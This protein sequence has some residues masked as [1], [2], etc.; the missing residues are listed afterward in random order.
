MPVAAPRPSGPPLNALRAF[1]AAARLGGFTAA[2]GE[3]CVTPGAI[4]QHVKTLEAW[5]G[6]QLFERHGKGVRLTDLGTAVVAEFSAAF[7]HLGSAVQSLRATAL[8][9]HVR[10]AALP[11]IAQLWLSPRLPDI[12]VN[13]PNV[14]ISITALET[15]PNLQREPYDLSIFFETG[16]LDGD[17]VLVT[18]DVIFPVCIPRLA[19]GLNAP[20]DLNNVT[21]LHDANW[22]QDWPAWLSSAHREHDIDGYGDVPEDAHGDVRGPTFSLYSLALEEAL[23]GAG[24]LMAHEALVETHLERGAL[25]AP[26]S[27][28]VELQQALSIRLARTSPPGSP[29]GLIVDRL[30][31]GGP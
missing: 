30:M 15:A 22:S 1:E 28:K 23:N 2:A 9:N 25:V 24:V 7:D 18:R 29:I 19:S 11:S 13:V 26:F 17:V 20:G 3:L 16:G 27:T 10:I 31:A 6:A 12:R 8:P 21:C 14:T 4:A 5:A